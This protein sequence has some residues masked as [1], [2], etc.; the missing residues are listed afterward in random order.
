MCQTQERSASLAAAA[1]VL[2]HSLECV[3]RK[4]HEEIGYYLRPESFELIGS[5]SGPDYWAP[6]GT[7]HGEIF[8]ARDVPVDKLAVTEG[9]LQIVAFHEIESI[10]DS[11][12]LP[13]TYA[14]GIFLKREQAT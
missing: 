12:A 10:R 7:L 14:L 5:Y 1:K 4:V 6:N 11:L 3:V 9:R 13:A 2:R 8:L